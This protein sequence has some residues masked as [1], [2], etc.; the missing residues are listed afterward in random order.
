[1]MRFVG[2]KPAEWLQSLKT[3]IK[4]LTAGRLIKG[5]GI[6]AGIP[7]VMELLSDR[8]ADEKLARAA[9]STLSIPAA[10]L[11]LALGGGPTPI[12]LALATLFG[13]VGSNIGSEGAE[14]GLN[15]LKGGPE[16]QAARA[17][18]KQAETQAKMADIMLPV[19]QRR[20]QA[21]IDAEVARAEAM[22]PI[23]ND[24]RLRQALAAQALALQN[25]SREQGLA[26]SQ[27][28]AAGAMG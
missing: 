19:E 20:L 15:F 21:K 4:G 14:A 11:G 26:T 22:A 25:A 18:I 23:I 12:G 1:V 16:D 7:V 5:G 3:P 27:M 28:I 17:A 24:Q 6:A 2:D 10:A 8:P 13:T 9:G